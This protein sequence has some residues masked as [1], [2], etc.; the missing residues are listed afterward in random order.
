MREG[1]KLVRDSKRFASEQKG[2]SWWNFL[3][4]LAAFAVL[5]GVLCTHWS[6]WIRL[7]VSFLA[8]LLHI[9]L[10]V[11]YHDY[12]HGAILADSWIACVFF[13]I[14]GLLVLTPHS[15]WKSTHDHHH[16][17]N[18]RQLGVDTI[19]SYPVMTTAAYR[20]TSPA[21]RFFY[22]LSR[23]PLTILFGYL[24]VF[25][26]G[27]CLLPIWQN[28][29]R[30]LDAVLSVGLHVGL[31]VVLALIRP[32]VMLL[33]VVLPWFVACAIGSYLF[34]AQHN[35]PGVRLRQGD[36]W[37]YVVAA[38][39]S[40]SFI[41]MSPVM[42]WFTGNIGYHHVHHLN[43]RIPF[44][45]LPETM[46]ALEDLQT[47]G[48]TTLKPVDI[49]RCLRLNLWD[50]EQDRFVSFAEARGRNGSTGR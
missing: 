25:F 20:K 50:P 24:T 43:S 12:A 9:R 17:N 45:R 34:Y 11:I 37:D 33:A 27:F 31:V 28:P 19:G 30:H 3:S 39:R 5:L 41:R 49:L 16:I 40:S 32:D 36:D 35:F 10:F 23:H 48:T 15:V 21:V 42:R 26:Y 29:R 38:L 4:T 7:P 8:A 18:T 13:R 1:R 47:P 6:W 22:I 14:Y 44:Y 46:A 2:R